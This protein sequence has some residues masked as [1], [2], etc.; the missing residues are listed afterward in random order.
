MVCELHPERLA[1]V[2]EPRE[3]L[4]SDVDALAEY[5]GGESHRTRSPALL[6][7]GRVDKVRRIQFSQTFG[8]V[9]FG[10]LDDIGD[11]TEFVNGW[12]AWERLGIEPDL[13]LEPCEG[14]V[15]LTTPLPGEVAPIVG[16][17]K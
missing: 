11:Q 12:P 10:M 6:S 16:T 13:L 17:G 14:G 15:R 9:T 8:G 7:K 5:R 1:S 2:M 4:W 3:C